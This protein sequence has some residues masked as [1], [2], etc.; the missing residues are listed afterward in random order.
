MKGQ[1]EGG[2]GGTC[3]FTNYRFG[4]PTPTQRPAYKVTVI[5]P[6]EPEVT[7]LILGHVA[8][9]QAMMFLGAHR[10]NS[11]LRVEPVSA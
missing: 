6:G 5:T 9:S 4:D 7:S 10:K 3:V 8:V 11:L 2:G 1:V